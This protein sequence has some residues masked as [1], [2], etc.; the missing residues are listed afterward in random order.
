MTHHSGYSAGRQCALLLLAVAALPSARGAEP[1]RAGPAGQRDRYADALPDG[2]IVRLG[3]VRPRSGARATSLEFL[4]DGKTVVSFA[5]KSICLWEVATGRQLHLPAA[6]RAALDAPD[7]IAWS[8]GGRFLAA[9]GDSDG[10]QRLCIW[11]KKSGKNLHR[12]PLIEEPIHALTFSPDGRTLALGDGSTV[13]LCDPATGRFFRRLWAPV[14]QPEGEKVEV[15]M[16][17]SSDGRGLLTK[18]RGRLQLWETTTGKVRRSFEAG[19]PGCFAFSPDSQTV[20]AATAEAILLWGRGDFGTPRRLEQKEVRALT[21][22]QAG[23]VLAGVSGNKTLTLWDTASG[24]ALRTV[25]GQGGNT[26]VVAFS[27]DGRWLAWATADCTIQLWDLATGTQRAELRGHQADVN[28]LAFSPDGN[29]LASSSVDHPPVRLW[30]V[31]ARKEKPYPREPTTTVYAL[32]FAPDGRTL[33]AGSED[34]IVRLWDVASGQVKSRLRGHRFAVLALAFSPDGKTLASGSWDSSVRLWDLTTGRELPRQMRHDQPVT[35]VAF[36]AKGR[37]L[38]SGS[39]NDVVR[40]W[41][42]ITGEQLRTL[43]PAVRALAISPDGTMLA[44]GRERGQHFV[45]LWETST[46]KLLRHT[47]AD[48]GAVYAVAFSPDGKRFAFAGRGEVHLW[49]VAKWRELRALLGDETRLN[50]LCFSP[51]GKLLAGGGAQEVVRLWDTETGKILREF[52]G[53]ADEV[54]AVTFS[55]D[56]R[57]LA[58][59]G[60]DATVL[61][62]DIGRK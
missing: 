3:T 1:E 6:V 29:T 17:F 46:G 48:V 32:A 51:D 36:A 62:W 34:Q 42:P 37:L 24:K 5:E 9:V 4:A 7:K 54:R 45:E 39:L 13:Y 28:F 55:P 38:A 49:D 31:R 30:D 20:A 23:T 60:S 2:A 26:A 11:D 21:F 40:L 33:A 25:Q 12:I 56:G 53:H 59:G 8:N 52:T 57:L 35:A 16:I 43:P 15:S 10:Q 14:F 19:D 18:R 47:P 27:P 22:V 41:D 50:A 58:S 61:I 44:T